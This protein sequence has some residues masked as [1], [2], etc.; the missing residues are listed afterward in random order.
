MVGDLHLK[1][2][3]R[4]HKLSSSSKKEFR[5]IFA[6]FQGF[7]FLFLFCFFLEQTVNSSDRLSFLKPGSQKRVMV[8][9]VYGGILSLF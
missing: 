2:G 5:G 7:L 6:Y 3:G 1:A 8:G 9:G 4:G